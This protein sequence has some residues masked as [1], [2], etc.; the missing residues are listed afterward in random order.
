MKKENNG[1]ADDAKMDAMSDTVKYSAGNEG[2]SIADDSDITPEE[3]ALLDAAGEDDEER[4]LHSAELDST[5][6]DNEA[7]NEKTS[8]NAKSGSDLDVPGAEEDNEDEK[9]GE[10]D[11]ENNNYSQA[12]TA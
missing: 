6:D 3:L 7:L 8:A 12:D 11:E 5:D 10:E 9:T 1:S 4:D 2:D